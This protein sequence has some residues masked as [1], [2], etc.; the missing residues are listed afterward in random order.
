MDEKE[1]KQKEPGCFEKIRE[2]MARE[3]EGGLMDGL[4]MLGVIMAIIYIIVAIICYLIRWIHSNLD[5]SL[6]LGVPLVFLVVICVLY[7]ANWFA[8]N[9]YKKLKI[10]TIWICGVIIALMCIYVP[11]YYESGSDKIQF[12]GYYFLWNIP[13]DYYSIRFSSTIFKLIL[14]IIPVIV[15]GGLLFYTFHGIDKLKKD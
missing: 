10:I 14:Q 2:I 12:V 9:T 1:L 15:I 3:R 13:E 8:T 5:L 6:C 7:E 4:V 11:I